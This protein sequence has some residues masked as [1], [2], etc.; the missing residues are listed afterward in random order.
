[1]FTHLLERDVSQL[2]AETNQMPHSRGIE[3]ALFIVTYGLWL[4][5]SLLGLLLTITDVL[6]ASHHALLVSQLLE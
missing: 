6:P 4:V 5:T 1:M 3:I 2:P